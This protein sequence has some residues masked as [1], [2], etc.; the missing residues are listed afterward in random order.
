MTRIENGPTPLYALSKEEMSRL[1]QGIAL[2]LLARPLSI[3][4][5]PQD[6]AHVRFHSVAEAE[7]VRSYIA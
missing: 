3:E 5:D 6:G 4:L 7:R 2:D 1:T